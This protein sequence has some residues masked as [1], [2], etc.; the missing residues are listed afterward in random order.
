MRALLKRRLTMY[1]YFSLTNGLFF[2]I[3]LIPVS[4]L[5]FFAGGSIYAPKRK[6]TLIFIIIIGLFFNA[7]GFAVAKK[8]YNETKK[9]CDENKEKGYI[10]KNGWCYMPLKEKGF[11]VEAKSNSV[12]VK[13][14]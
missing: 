3:S 2:I 11:Y 7:L 9:Y 10:L 1:N 6:K 13:F 8:S 5:V 14:D 12:V 4:L